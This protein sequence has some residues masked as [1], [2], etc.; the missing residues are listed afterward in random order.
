MEVKA[1]RTDA[2]R[3]TPRQVKEAVNRKDRFLLCVVPVSSDVEPDLDLV[4]DKMRFVG[5]VGER[6]N[7][8]WVALNA[9]EALEAHY[10]SEYAD[11]VRLTVS[12]GSKRISVDSSVWKSDGF[13]LGE[14]RDRLLG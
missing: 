5:G 6:V 13:S 7:K 1:T 14:L 11:G 12:G 10:T 3:M 8:A 4:E 9:M 2:A